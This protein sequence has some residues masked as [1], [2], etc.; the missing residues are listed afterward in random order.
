[1]NT[2]HL[3]LSG[4][5]NP[6]K[7][8]SGVHNSSGEVEKKENYTDIIKNFKP[9]KPASKPATI[10]PSISGAAEDFNYKFKQDVKTTKPKKS[11][12]RCASKLEYF[13]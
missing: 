7:G 12:Q 11:T 2:N 6:V 5:S 8:N 13:T 9:A 1:V 4:Y 10:G 3:H